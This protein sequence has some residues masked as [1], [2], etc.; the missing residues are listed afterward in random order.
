MRKLAL[1]LILSAALA[2]VS[3]QTAQA[4]GG[5]FC[6]QVQVDQTA[7]RI[8]FALGPNKVTAYIQINYQ[9]EAKKFS[10]VVPVLAQPTIK[11]GSQSTFTIMEQL[12]RPQFNLDY[13][14]IAGGSCFQFPLAGNAQDA[15][16]G[17]PSDKGVEVLDVKQV[18]PFDTVV[19]KSKSTTELVAWLTANGYDQPPSSTPLIDYYVKQG[20]LFVAVK[21][22]KSAS[23]GEI[24]PLALEMDTPEA[25]VPLILTQIAAE[26]NM[27]V[28]VYVLGNGRAFP[29]NWFHVDMDYAQVNWSQNGSNYMA[30][31]TAAIDEAAGHGF[32]TEFAG[33]STIAKGQLFQPGRFSTAG[34]VGVTDPSDVLDQLLQAGFPRDASMQALLREFIPEPAELVAQGVDE[35]TFYNSI[36]QYEPQLNG[37]KVDSVGLVKALEDRLITPLKEAQAL[38]D[39]HP[40]LT[41][42]MSTVSPSEMNRDPLFLLNPDLPAVSN[43]H[44][45]KVSG[46]C[47]A[48]NGQISNMKLTLEDGQVLSLGTTSLFGGGTPWMFET[49]VPRTKSIEL[50]GPAGMP[51]KIRRTEVKRI[52]EELNKDAAEVVRGRVIADNANQ[53]AAPVAALNDDSGCSCSLHRQTS[54][55]ALSVFALFGVALLRVSRRKRR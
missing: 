11:L 42:L 47:S 50:V 35:R 19:L 44:T 39:E 20:M 38:F 15:A 12:T 48:T 36:A 23:V 25:C 54:A 33:A 2:T 37:F 43:V 24:A 28:V 16:A 34:L 10:W 6:S 52:D 14:G 17:P 49:K 1:G 13:S 27:P 55:S 30:M 22:T 45:A 8:I 31:A 7:E 53:P 5:F 46:M 40:F 3:Q 21:L 9:G 4:C 51:V 18:G 32:I 29:K 41:R 26:P